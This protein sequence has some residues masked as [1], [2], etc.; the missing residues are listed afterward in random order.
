MIQ[1]IHHVAAVVRDLASGYAVW[2]DALG[3]PVL[4]E[5]ELSDQGVRAAL[6]AAGSCEVELVEPVRSDTGVARFLDSRG[7]GLHHLCFE[8]DD[9]ERDLERLAATDVTLIDARPR[10]GLAGLIA[11]LH[12][13]SCGGVLV[14]L[15]TPAEPVRLPVTPATLEVVHVAVESVHET[16]AGYQNLFGLV[17]GPAPPG[18]SVVQLRLGRVVVQLAAQ[19]RTHGRSGLAALGLS[20]PD[21]TDLHDR[22]AR[23]GVPVETIAG[24]LVVPPAATHGVPL[25][26]RRAEAST[27]TPARA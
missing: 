10:P 13:R 24:G 3:L 22:L 25:I 5:A 9:V 26:F 21:L 2:R 4:R 12:P 23:H 19:S 7:E 20:A 11:F 16:A 8:S 15:A 14:E 17:P 1:R 27:D 18:E 6:L